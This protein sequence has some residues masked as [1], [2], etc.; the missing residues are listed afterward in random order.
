MVSKSRIC[1]SGTPLSKDPLSIFGQALFL[2][3]GVYG[4]SWPRFRATYGKSGPF[5]VNQIVG[6]K[7]L[8]ILSEK[9]SLFTFSA[10]EEVLDLPEM[11]SIQHILQFE[12]TAQKIYKQFEKE[13]IAE[14]GEDG[15]L[16]TA[17][18]VLVKLIRLQQM[19]SGMVPLDEEPLDFSG[20]IQPDPREWVLVS[21]QKKN[22]LH[23]LLL[24]IP[25]DEPAV[26]FCKF[27]QDLK[28]VREIA[29]KTGRRYGEI[30]G[31]QKDLTPDAKMPDWVD[32]MGVQIQS[33]GVGIDL[34]RARYEFYYSPG[35]SLANY[36]QSL[37]RIYRPGQTRSVFCYYL[38]VE[39]TVDEAVYKALDKRQEINDVVISYLKE[40]QKEQGLR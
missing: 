19:T 6:Y 40:L 28:V 38:I 24:D 22:A 15:G 17:E 7:D 2:D 37:A 5:G 23:E 30:S 27:K 12:P 21:E 8:D 26:V 11:L 39:G 20:E 34:T 10:G 4:A 31:D 13:C 9:M 18:N 35:H 32:L 33:G 16:L 29:E 14:I 36:L 25:V 3:R 1:L